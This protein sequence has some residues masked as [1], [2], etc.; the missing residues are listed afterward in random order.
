MVPISFL[1]NLLLDQALVFT[2]VLARVSGVI[3]TVPIFGSR[4]VP[5]PARALLTVAMA[6]LITPTQIGALRQRPQTIVDYALAGTGE[7]LIGVVLGLGVVIL[8]AGVQLAGQLISQLSGMALADVFQ[9]GLDTSMPVISQLLVQV[10]LAV[11]VLAGGHRLV[12]AGLLDTFGSVPLGVGLTGG[13][14]VAG[15]LALLAESFELGVRAAAPAVTALLLATLLMGLVSRTMPQINI[16]VVGFGAN[17]MVTL[18][19]VLFSLAAV[20]WTFNDAIG[21]ALDELKTS[22]AALG[23]P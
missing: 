8:L 13:S 3:M 23:L 10:A 7:L 11:F 9:P 15:L 19:V 6:L 21:P 17:V 4:Q 2:L 5:I 20:A 18:A 22:L 1:Q 16:L 14:V 12:M